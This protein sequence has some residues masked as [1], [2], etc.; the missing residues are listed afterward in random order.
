M[1]KGLNDSQ[2]H[3]WRSI[4]AL[5]H[6]D[7]VVTDEEVQYM[8]ERL[9]EIPFSQEQHDILVKDSVEPQNVEL[10]FSRITDLHD[11]ALFFKHAHAVVHVDGDYAVEEQQILLKLNELHAKTANVDDLI[12]SIKLEFEEERVHD[13]DDAQGR[14]KYLAAVLF[15]LKRK[16]W[17]E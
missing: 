13:F 12:G 17:G 1:S 7:N 4:F 2:F 15:S 5:V 14:K 11:Q 8:A 6:V 9:K 10:M 16:I 3:M